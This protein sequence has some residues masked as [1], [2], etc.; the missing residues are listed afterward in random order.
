MTDPELPSAADYIALGRALR[1]MRRRA[2]LTQVQTAEQ[3]GMRDTFISQIEN[4]HRGMRWHSLL[5]FL[6]AY[7][8]SLRELAELIEADS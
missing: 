7:D 5:A 6:N 1:T 8:S 3:V 4:G 2:G